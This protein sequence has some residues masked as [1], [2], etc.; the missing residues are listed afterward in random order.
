LILDSKVEAEFLA[1]LVQ[2]I[3]VATDET[4]EAIDADFFNVESYKWLVKLL[5]GKQWKRL[6]FGFLDQELTSVPDDETRDRYKEQISALYNRNLTFEDEAKD[7]VKAWVAWS[8]VNSKIRQ[9]VEAL[10]RS[11]RVDFFLKDI[12]DGV[13]QAQGV[14]E[15]K[16]FQLVDYAE[17]Y[18]ER[19]QLRKLSRDNPSINP[20]I[21]TGIP[22]LDAQFIFKAPMIVNFLAPFKRYKSIIL[23]AMSYAGFLQGFNVLHV[24]FENSMELTNAR[25]DAMFMETNFNRIRNYLITQEEKES[26]DRLFEWVRNWNNRLKI[27]KCVPQETTVQQVEDE[28]KK[29]QDRY[30]ISFALETWDYLNLIKPSII[31][32]ED[33]LNQTRSVWDLKNHLDAFNSLAMVASQS[34]V[35]GATAE[36]LNKS[37]QGKSVGI[38][39]GVDLTINIDQDANEEE[40]GFIILSPSFIRDGQIK[41]PEIVLDADIERMVID[42]NLHALWKHAVRVNPI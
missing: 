10:N 1:A 5:K 19:Q 31:K 21:L 14:I 15:G 39:Q 27:I 28:V 29:I 2:G 40:E 7:K 41:I 20:R 23:N 38:S 32:K 34:K 6:P 35:E 17:N 12:R 3:D 22:G 13:T 36:R 18:Q 4:L 25:F 30:G 42:R 9:S 11:D 24:T 37:H 26:M 33:H 8:V 16:K